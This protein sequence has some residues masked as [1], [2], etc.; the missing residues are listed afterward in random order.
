MLLRFLE[1]REVRPLGSTKTLQVHVRLI[2]ATNKDL[3]GAIREKQFRPDLYDRL[4]EVVLEVPPLRKRRED[5]PL[6]VEHFLA[7]YTRIPGVTV[8]GVRPRAFRL[9]HAY[10]WP[11]N[12]RELKTAIRRGVI[13]ADGGWIEPEH[14]GL[15]RD[16][17]DSSDGAAQVEPEAHLTGLSLRQREALRIV[18]QYGAVRRADLTSRFGISESTAQ[19]DLVALVEA[20]V[21]SRSGSGRGPR[22]LPTRRIR[23]S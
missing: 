3:E 7:L 8:Q 22:Y 13:F 20:R 17:D 5:I 21:L 10:P 19:R 12:V 6:L 14:L 9:L 18:S 23:A 1:Q 16:R 2:A 11:G 4:S 15:P